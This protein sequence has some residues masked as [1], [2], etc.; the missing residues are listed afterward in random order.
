MIEGNM[1]DTDTLT[2]RQERF[3]RDF[4]VDMNGTKASVRAGYGERSA[5][6]TAS[7]LLTNTKV[8]ARV[9]ELQAETAKRLEVTADT[10]MADLARLC[11][12]AV[13]AKQFG[14]AVR[15]KELQGKRLGLFRDRLDFNGGP[16]RDRQIIEAVAGSDPAKRA[17]LKVLMGSAEVF[18]PPPPKLVVDND[19]V[20]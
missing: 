3:C 6:V 2:P 12:E 5:H 14:P 15:A 11:Q 17:A 13:E 19:G 4:L 18:D 7:R 8:A 16:E 10:V 1:D 20:A 9:A